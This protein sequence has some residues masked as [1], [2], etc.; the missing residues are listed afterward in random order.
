[1]CL[2]N[3]CNSLVFAS[4]TSLN[5]ILSST[6]SS[7][8]ADDKFTVV[9]SNAT[10][11][12]LIQ[13]TGPPLAAMAKHLWGNPIPQFLNAMTIATHMAIVDTGAMSIFI[14]EGANMA[15]KQVARKPLTIN[16][17]DGNK[18]MSHI[19]DI[20]IPGLPTVLT[21]HIVPSLAI[22]S[23]IGI[24]PLCKAGCAVLFDNDKFDV[25]FNG[26]VIL[27]G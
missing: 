4:A 25:M 27:R 17:P 21:G 15:N 1:M 13:H 3:K 14:M 22:A 5:P 20:N 24:C 11:L 10:Q 8:L 23:L 12:A 16:L 7:L 19:C 6:S 2:A 9:T 18:V 26:K